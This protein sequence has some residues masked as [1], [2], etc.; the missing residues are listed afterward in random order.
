MRRALFGLGTTGFAAIAAALLLAVPARAT[1]EAPDSFLVP[2]SRV[3]AAPKIDGTIGDPLW[4]NA[5]HVQLDWD[6]QFR[7]PASEKTDVYLMADD[8]NLYVAFVAQQSEPITA[9]QRTND[10]GLSADDVVRLFLWPGGDQGF[11]YLFA[12]NPIGT[13]NESSTENASFAPHWTA[14]A[15]RT[16][17]G[18]IV[19]EEIPL[20]SMRGDGRPTWRLQLARQV[21]VTGQEFEWAHNPAAGSTDASLYAGYLSGMKALASSTRT[22]PRV[23]LYSLGQIGAAS[24][25]GDTSRMGADIALPVTDTASFFGTVHPDYSNVELDQQTISPTAFTRRYQEVR[26][27]F[28]QGINFYNTFNCNDC[29]DYPILYTPD[30]PT[31]RDGYAV[32]G[33]QDRIQFAAFDAVGDDGRLDDAQSASFTTANHDLNAGV[34]RFG[35]TL[36]G[37]VDDTFLYQ[38][39]VGNGHNFSAYGTGGGDRG[40]FVPDPSLG[41]YR[42]YGINLYNPKAGFFAAYH[43][44]G[45]Q[46]DPLDGFVQFNDLVG[47]SV[48]AYKEIDYAP[49]S[50]IQNFTVSQDFQQYHTHDGAQSLSDAFTS[51][52]VN[53][54]TLYNLSLSSGYEYYGG[55]MLDQN[56]A[57]LTYGA[58]SAT[59]TSV[60]YNIGRF[61]QGYL[62]STT[63]LT[64]LKLGAHGTLTFEADNTNDTTD[65]DQRL[66]QWL[67]RASVA[68][69]LTPGSSVAIGIR[70]IIGTSPLIDE[71]LPSPASCTNLLDLPAGC[72]SSESNLS[73]SYYR[74]LGHDELYLVYGN[75]NAPTTAPAFILKYIHYFGAEKGT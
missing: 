67:E 39:T 36:P 30:I 72:Y 32:E 71:P 3:T 19:T 12:A 58:T 28:T 13:R 50:F 44:V 29:I 5:A 69:Q 41:E 27:F 37:I 53:T 2:L 56:G 15:T 23:G 47:P 43:D 4:K 46:Y 45:S 54:K 74:R 1:T 48:Y 64:T 35:S 31:P 22:K 11:E 9:T 75:P 21:H 60:S 8:K 10:V 57:G 62:R 25:G 26:P 14:V 73:F 70:R 34:L 40:T 52:S 16:S 63:R 49:S 42:E 38:M 55:V 18:Y 6:F 66:V 17:D 68:Y 65:E 24:A 59:P 7:R 51:L 61:G 20:G 33:T